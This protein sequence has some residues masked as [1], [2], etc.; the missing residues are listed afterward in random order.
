MEGYSDILGE[1]I[2]AF[3]RTRQ[4]MSDPFSAERQSA[5]TAQNNR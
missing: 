5:L 4:G 2:A 3:W 1:R